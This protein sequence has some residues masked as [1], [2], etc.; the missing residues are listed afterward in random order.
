MPINGFGVKFRFFRLDI[1]LLVGF[2]YHITAQGP[3]LTTP[4]GP[5]V[6]LWAEKAFR[7]FSVVGPCGGKSW[8]SFSFRPLIILGRPPPSKHS[9]GQ[10]R[11]HHSTQWSRFK[12]GRIFRRF[13]TAHLLEMFLPL[14]S[15]EACQQPWGSSVGFAAGTN[16]K[17]NGERQM[18]HST[19][20]AKHVSI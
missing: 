5:T 4:A 14:W 17:E 18:E 15:N 12:G 7:G 9:R 2:I 13:S 6:W 11:H 16:A 1:L 20:Q 10:G 3:R 19:A 8:R